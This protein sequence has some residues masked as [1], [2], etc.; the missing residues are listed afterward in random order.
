[1]AK[2]PRHGPYRPAEDGRSTDDASRRLKG[3]GI[4]EEQAEAI[5]EVVNE[6]A[7]KW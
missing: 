4:Q 2:V 3:V 6:S 5:V 7:V 1:M